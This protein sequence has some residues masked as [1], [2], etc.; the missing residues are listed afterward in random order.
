ME[1]QTTHAYSNLGRAKVV[2]KTEMLLA[3]KKE[4]VI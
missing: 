3:V 1:F 4:E 2:N